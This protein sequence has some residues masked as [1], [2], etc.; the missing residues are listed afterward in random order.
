MRGIYSEETLMNRTR[1]YNRMERK[2]IRLREDKKISTVSPKNMTAEDVRIYLMSEKDR[3][4]PSDFRHE[5]N[6]L[7]KLLAFVGNEEAISVCLARNPGIAPVIRHKRIASLDDSVYDK[8]LARSKEIDPTDFWLVRAYT[9]VLMCILTGAR[10]KEIRLANADDV[11]THE[12]IFEI[13]HV[14]GEKTY[15]QARQV[16]IHPD[17][18]PLLLTY[19]LARKKWMLD[20]YV[21]S[22]A[23]FPSKSSA[24]G[25]LCG[26][27]LTVIKNKVQDDIGIKFDLRTCRRTF[28][29]RYMDSGL[30]LES[31]SVLMGHASTR[32]TEGYYCRRKLTKAIRSAEN[33][34]KNASAGSA[35]DVEGGGS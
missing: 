26:N 19:L 7:K 23:L 28:G 9:L 13:I 11:D 22:P 2:L 27:A 33:T 1:R 5:I 34:W 35:A 20:N 25:Y 6:A 30:D 15:G 16:P 10:N 4:S 32:T 29:Q 24:D 21:D 12:W 3:V 31:T 17:V 18:R 14:K 8:I